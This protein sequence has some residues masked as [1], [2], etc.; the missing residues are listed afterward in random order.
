[1]YNTSFSGTF[2]LGL[3]CGGKNLEMGNEN[4]RLLLQGALDSLPLI[5]AAI[6][7]GIIYGA[8]AQ[9]NGLSI[10]AT[11]AM[12]LVVFAGSSQFVAV[13]L[14]AVNASPW[15]IVITTFVVNLR[16]FLYAVSLIPHVRE[17]G[18]GTRALM[19][20]WL[21]DETYAVVSQWLARSEHENLDTKGLPYLYFGSALL[22]YSNWFVCTLIGV[23]L[24]NLIPEMSAWGLEIAM[25]V[26]FVGIVIPQLTSVSMWICSGTAMVMALITWNWP[27]KIGL[28]I[29]ALVAIAV[30]MLVEMLMN[31]VKAKKVAAKGSDEKWVEP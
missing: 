25:V 31:N 29:S 12:S 20:F 4:R 15:V 27:Q 30:G 22:M 28:V 11:L 18:Q 8:L 26:A 19:G 24:G 9:T 3:S 6:P 14:L 16:H 1:M 23:Y 13:S 5:V 10:V 21:T 7:F 2:K 17:L